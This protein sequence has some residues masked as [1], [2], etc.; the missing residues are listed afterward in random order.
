M[1]CVSLVHFC[2]IVVFRR[3]VYDREILKSPFLLRDKLKKS[4]FSLIEG[5]DLNVARG[6]TCFS[7]IF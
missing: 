4:L 6:E 7:N 5:A 1:Y 3:I 2:G